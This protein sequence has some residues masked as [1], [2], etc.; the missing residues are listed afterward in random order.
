MC[1]YEYIFPV[2][3]MYKI[4]TKTMLKVSIMTIVLY[5]TVQHSF[6]QFIIHICL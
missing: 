6:L 3:I 2:L 5:D 1:D 4:T